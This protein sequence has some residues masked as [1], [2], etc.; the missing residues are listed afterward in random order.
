MDVIIINRKDARIF[1]E[2]I[3][4]DVLIYAN[5]HQTEYDEFVKFIKSDGMKR[6]DENQNIEQTHCQQTTG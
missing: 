5:K 1:A 2:T 4:N 3:F 6:M